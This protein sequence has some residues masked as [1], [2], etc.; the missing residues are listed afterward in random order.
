MPVPVPDP[1]IEPIAPIVVYPI[2]ES[3]PAEVYPG[4]ESF[5]A[6]VYP[7]IESTPAEV[8]PG[9]ESVPAEIHP[10]DCVYQAQTYPGTRPNGPMVGELAIVLIDAFDNTDPSY[11]TEI[12][13]LYEG[14]SYLFTGRILPNAE[15]FSVNFVLD[16]NDVALHINPRFRTQTVVRNSKVRGSWA[17]EELHSTLPFLFQRGESFAI[18][19]L[20]TQHSYLMS[21]NGHHMEPF[22]HRLSYDKVRYLQVKGNADDI[23]IHRSEI[24]S[25]PNRYLDLLPAPTVQFE[26]HFVE[27]EVEPLNEGDSFLFSGKID[28][29]CEEFEISFLFAND[30]RDIPLHM[31]SRFKKNHFLRNSRLCNEWN[32]EEISTPNPFRKGERFTIQVLVTIDF[33]VIAIN[34]RH[35]TKFCHRLPFQGVGL[36]TVKGGVFDVQMHRC[37]VLD[38]PQST[39]QKQIL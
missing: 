22:D 30:T 9:Y 25:Y 34:G 23:R 37:A 20:I 28:R 7:G 35:Y 36:I 10:G 14:A 16:N 12:G 17:R 3:V 29:K 26:P 1:V 31:K 33:Y 2:V 8:H 13:Q 19:V 39:L 11:R 6:E 38:Y 32:R 21:F 18:Q 24:R 5:P 15:S 4:T 27:A